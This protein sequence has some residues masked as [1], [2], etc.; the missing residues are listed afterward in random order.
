MTGD[1]WERFKEGE[2]YRVI[3]FSGDDVVASR[4][5]ILSLNRDLTRLSYLVEISEP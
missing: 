4:S 1:A 2:E 5:D 3:V